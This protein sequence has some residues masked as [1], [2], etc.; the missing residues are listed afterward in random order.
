MTQTCNYLCSNK[1]G[2][3]KL[4]DAEQNSQL[5]DLNILK[6]KKKDLSHFNGWENQ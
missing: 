4:N 3:A 1:S 5:F 2:Y 6:A